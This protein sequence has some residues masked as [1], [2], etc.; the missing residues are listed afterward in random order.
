MN[1]LLQV[2]TARW[3]V[4]LVGALALAV[5]VWFLGP[6][7]AIA[8]HRPLESDLVRAVLVAAILVGWGLFNILDRARAAARNEQMISAIGTGAGTA[9]AAPA[10]SEGEQLR[11]RLE[12][13]L[14]D[15]KRLRGANRRGRTYLYELPWYI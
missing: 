9:A 7:I 8:E 13:A 10:D 6:V 14:R 1:R 4:T 5:L 2:L 15:L 12:E 11:E 3:L